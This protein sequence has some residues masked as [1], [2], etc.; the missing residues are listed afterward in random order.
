MMLCEVWTINLARATIT[1]S[2]V[3]I[4]L[5]VTITSIPT[6]I[7]VERSEEVPISLPLFENTPCRILTVC[8]RITE[9]THPMTGLLPE[10]EPLVAPYRAAGRKAY[11]RILPGGKK[12]PH[13]HVDCA[14]HKF[15]PKDRPPKTNATRVKLLGILD[16]AV[17][18]SLECVVRGG[19]VV[20]L[21]DLPDQGIIR[22]LSA[23]QKAGELSARLTRGECRIEGAPV[24]QLFW[25]I[26]DDRHEV[27]VGIV[28]SRED[29]VDGRYLVRAFDWIQK[30]FTL[31]VL[32]KAADANG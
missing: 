19:F 11:L 5:S 31:L 23:E 21:A 8:G 28:G 15:F 1:V 18:L 13:L 17:G 27:F 29:K 22:A 26:D 4:Y 20:S 7:R 32:G 30:Q 24:R 14:L 10:H 12:N 16:K 25:N 6:G 3:E 2:G 9:A